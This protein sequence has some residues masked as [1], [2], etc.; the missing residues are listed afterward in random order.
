M[1]SMNDRLYPVET[2]GVNDLDRLRAIFLAAF[3]DQPDLADLTPAAR[4]VLATSA[5]LFY[6]RGA[7]DTSVRDLTKACG[8]SPGAL[9]NHFA[10]KDDLLYT[11]VKHGHVRIQARIRRQLDEAADDPTARFAAFVTAYLRGH[12]SNPELAQVVR[13]E[14]L[15]LSAERYAEIVDMRRALRT[16][17]TGLITD[18][19]R[20]DG[21][22]LIN[23]PSGA[24]GSALMVLDMCSRTSDWFDRSRESDP[25]D[26]TERYVLAALR[27]VGAPEPR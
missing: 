3:E 25:R 9:Y 1:H 18:G 21:F 10:S 5:A 24:V 8:L 20:A 2:T 14:Y 15:H 12:V 13:R 17:L 16:E 4:R 27:I 11:L 7:V 19:C 6:E 23:G 26:I 22:D